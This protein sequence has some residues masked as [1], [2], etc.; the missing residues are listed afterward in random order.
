MAVTER[1]PAREADEF[2]VPTPEE[3]E[4]GIE[5]GARKRR[6]DRPQ[7]NRR[8]RT[9]RA[10]RARRL[11]RMRRGVGQKRTEA[12]AP[13]PI[14]SPVDPPPDVSRTEPA[15]PLQTESAPSSRSSPSTPSRPPGRRTKPPEISPVLPVKGGKPSSSV[16]SGQRVRRIAAPKRKVRSPL[17]KPDRGPVPDD[18]M[19]KAE[20]LGHRLEFQEQLTGSREH[21]RTFVSDCENCGSKAYARNIADDNYALSWDSSTW[22]TQGPAFE[23]YCSGVSAR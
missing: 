13:T 19:A 11:F 6:G 18:I 15:L 9:S 2:Y 23:N 14:P 4:Q 1:D 10:S 16:S 20:T 5:S 17:K 22:Q 3:L 21:Q 8:P 7:G 12:P